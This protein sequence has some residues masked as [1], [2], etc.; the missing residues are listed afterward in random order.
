MFEKRI[1]YLIY[2]RT[3]YVTI[4]KKLSAFVREAFRLLIF[5]SFL[6]CIF[7]LKNIDKGGLLSNPRKVD[8]VQMRTCLFTYHISD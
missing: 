6:K 2:L 3:I 4:G 8:F 7:V 1:P 5:M